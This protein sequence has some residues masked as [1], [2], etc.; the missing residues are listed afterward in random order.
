MFLGAFSTF[1]IYY[2]REAYDYILLVFFATGTCWAGLRLLEIW[3]AEKRID[4]RTAIIYAVFST[5]LLHAHLS[6]L[7][8]LG[9]WTAL[10]LWHLYADKASRPLV[11]GPLGLAWLVIFGFA[12]VTFL[13][14]LFRVFGFTAT[15]DPRARRISFVI[16]PSLA[17]RMGWGEGWYT[18]IPFLAALVAGLWSFV[19]GKNAATRRVRLIAIQGVAYFFIQTWML[20]V[21][22]FEVRYYAALL[23]ILLLFAA[24]G[25][26]FA[27]RR[28]KGRVPALSGAF[29]DLLLAVPLAAWLAANAWQVMQIEC[30][31]QNYKG[32]ARW[33]NE[34]LPKNGIYSFWNGY[35]MRGVPSVYQ[36]P[37]RFATFPI[38]WS[39]DAD[40]RDQQVRE[41][42]T[43]FFLRFPLAAYVELYPD[44]ILH[45]ATAHNEPVQRDKLFAQ[46]VWL[47]DPAY[48]KLVEWQTL[49]LGHAQWLTEKMDHILISYN[50][51]DDLPAVAAKQ[52]KK[53]YHYFGDD[54]QYAKDQQM[55]DW[56]VTASYGTFFLGNTGQ[57]PA[58]VTLTL[59]V[60]AMPSAC[61]LSIYSAAGGKLLDHAAVPGSY[62]QIVVPPFVLAPGKTQFNV[63]VLPTAGN[64]QPQL[65]IHGLQVEPAAP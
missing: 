28:L 35:E 8:C 26:E 44:D 65:L 27:A 63:E 12:F 57:E 51:V 60:M 5:G 16:L 46:Q 34:N 2:S 64:F 42:L 29:P 39:S 23:P 55:N 19:R 15:E 43:S 25:L 18:M 53:L 24:A 10:M 36:T 30:R 52:G 37:E 33:L 47:K 9:S 7:L 50:K 49:P 40:Y 1:H 31:G 21:S 3:D 11:K 14:F 20:R 45:P 59:D 13:P 58:R 38:Y 17:G 62:K 32:L 61:E 48:Q 4:R 41:R 22:R 6:G 54:F 56:L